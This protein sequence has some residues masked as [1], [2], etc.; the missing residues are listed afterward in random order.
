MIETLNPPKSK[1]GDRKKQM[2]Q[3]EKQTSPRR[4][5]AQPPTTTL[6]VSGPHSQGRGKDHVAERHK[7]PDVNQEAA[8]D[9][10][11]PAAINWMKLRVVTPGPNHSPGEFYPTEK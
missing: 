8:D 4:S 7:L 1:G 5:E 6:S 2:R 11:N 3:K 9:P 10:H